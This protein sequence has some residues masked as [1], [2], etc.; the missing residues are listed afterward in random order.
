MLRLYISYAPA[1][2]PYLDELLKWLKP[3]EEKYFLRIYYPDLK[4]ATRFQYYKF[5]IRGPVMVY[6]HHWEDTLD[7]LSKAHVYLFLMS[8]HTLST[9][10]IEQEEIPR[11]VERYGQLGDKF[12][13]VYPVLVSPS[14]WETQSRI[15]GFKALGDPQ[16][17]LEDIKPPEEGYRQIMEQLD[18]V[19]EE[20]RRNWVEEQHRLGL[21]IDDFLT[22]E[23]PK[24]PEPAYQPIPGWAGALMVLIILYLVT[25]WYFTACAPRMYYLYTPKD[26]PYQPMP[27]RFWR[28]NPLRA[29]VDVPLRPEEDT[30]GR[31]LRMR[32]E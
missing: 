12:V 5:H 4:N 15:S 8:Y 27:E 1:D 17:T 28:P 6:P 18:K 31:G 10:Y 9:P 26:L 16:K 25:S 3:L 19:F 20:L 2:Q 29:P 23:L 22:P 14:L 11:A 13:R 24:P 7:Q 21:P 32:L 30:V